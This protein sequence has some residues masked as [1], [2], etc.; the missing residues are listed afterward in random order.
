MTGSSDKRIQ[1]W[2]TNTN[3]NDELSPDNRTL[4]GHD[5]SV[6][7]LA[8]S[9]DGQNLA[10]G[11]L[12]G[13]VRLW[14]MDL[15]RERL[16]L[17][18]HTGGIKALAYTEDNRILACGTGLDGILRLWDA[19]TSGQLSTLLDHA[20]LN[21]AVTFSSDGRTL[22]SGGNEDRT[23]LLSDVPKVINNDS[24]NS[25]LHSLTGNRHGI[26][27]ARFIFPDTRSA[28]TF[29]TQQTR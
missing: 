2:N 23:I 25:L 14:D 29:C 13:T 6:W 3:N 24:D 7:I 1:L 21:K 18:G 28:F 17:T 15:L 12:D 27:R 16:K 20:G 5:D 8:F 19:G 22:A 4:E 10:S 26:Y 11:S 9:K